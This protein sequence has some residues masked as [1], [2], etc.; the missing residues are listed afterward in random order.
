MR[1]QPEASAVVCLLDVGSWNESATG[2]LRRHAMASAV[3]D[4]PNRLGNLCGTCA[5]QPGYHLPVNLHDAAYGAAKRMEAAPINRGHRRL[6]FSRSTEP[7]H[8]PTALALGA[9][10]R[11]RTRRGDLYPP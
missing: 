4:Q 5:G 6:R 7:C 10:A 1:G 8:A 3:L 9:A 11:D 2:P